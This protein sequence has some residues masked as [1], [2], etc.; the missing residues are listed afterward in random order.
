[1]NLD[2]W[3]VIVALALLGISMLVGFGSLAAACGGA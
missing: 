1:M 2:S 3:P